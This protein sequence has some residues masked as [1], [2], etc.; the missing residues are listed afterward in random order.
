MDSAAI[1]SLRSAL[2]KAAH[3]LQEHRAVY[4]RNETAVSQQIVLPVLR[5]LGWD[6]ESPDEVHPEDRSEVGSPDYTLRADGRALV[7]IEVK[8][9]SVDV[10]VPGALEQ[11]HRY[12][13][14]KGVRLCLATNGETWVLARSFEEG[15]D[16]RG[17]VLWEVLLTESTIDAVAQKLTLIARTNVANIDDFVRAQDRVESEWEQLLG[18]P[19]A[20]VSSLVDLIETRLTSG[21]QRPRLPYDGF[22]EDYVSQRVREMLA[23]LDPPSEAAQP[24]GENAKATSPAPSYGRVRDNSAAGILV[25]AAERALREGRL[26][27]S[28]AIESGHTRYLVNSRPVHKNG[29]PFFSPR[30]LSKGLYI[31]THASLET[32]RRQAALLNELSRDPRRKS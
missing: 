8:N 24:T 13:S 15:R 22:V 3:R 1:A 7:T 26:L 10:A 23:P 32:A 5:S 6:V 2:A 16:L 12:A 21:A 20:L 27:P 19:A 9:S 29:K 30:P 11:A 18:E 31:E 14:A 17:R 25:E 28:N 4:H